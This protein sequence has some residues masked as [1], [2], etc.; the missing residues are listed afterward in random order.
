M[1][2]F[3]IVI[4]PGGGFIGPPIPGRDDNFQF[5]KL[6]AVFGP[7][8]YTLPDA[9][10]FLKDFAS[11]VGTAAAAGTDAHPFGA[12]RFGTEVVQFEQGA[13]VTLAA[14]EHRF[15]GISFE[16]S[17]QFVKSLALFSQP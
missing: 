12:F 2:V 8:V 10:P 6:F 14:V 17:E 13:I 1:I 11:P 16:E 3:E 5:L 9:K 7:P 4:D 15:L